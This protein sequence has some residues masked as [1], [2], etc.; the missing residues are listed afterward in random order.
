M[1]IYKSAR[2]DDLKIFYNGH[3]ITNTAV[4]SANADEGWIE[5]IDK[6]RRYPGGASPLINRAKGAFIHRRLYGR[7]NIFIQGYAISHWK[8]Y[9]GYS[10]NA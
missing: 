4:V 5:V 7:V 1:T 9:K 2:P 10:S 6:Y 3:D 8:G